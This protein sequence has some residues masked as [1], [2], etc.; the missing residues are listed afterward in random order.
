MVTTPKGSTIR[1]I[2]GPKEGIY[3]YPNPLPNALVFQA[4]DIGLHET[5]YRKPNSCTYLHADLIPS[6]EARKALGLG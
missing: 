2:G 6:E 5:Y 1:C 3:K 4:P